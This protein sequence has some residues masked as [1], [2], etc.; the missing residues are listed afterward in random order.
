VLILLAPLLL[1]LLPSPWNLVSFLV[2]LPLWVIELLAW[3]RTVSKRRHVVGVQTMIG[4]E[5]AVIARCAPRGQVT[6]DGEI[7]KA[8]CTHGAD[9]GEI[10]RITRVK[11]LTLIVEPATDATDRGI[12]GEPFDRTRD[13]QPEQRG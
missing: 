6:L 10:V 4:R 8:R 13:D 7:W 11:G 9:V 2:L 1:L 12:S 5:A 3:R